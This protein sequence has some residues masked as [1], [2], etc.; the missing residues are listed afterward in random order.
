M[1]GGVSDGSWT[2]EI[3]VPTVDGLGPTGAL[4]HTEDEYIELPSVEPR[5]EVAVRLCRELGARST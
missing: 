5:I 2:S 1:A 3:G 4:D